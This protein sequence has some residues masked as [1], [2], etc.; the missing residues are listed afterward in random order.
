MQNLEL[1]HVQLRMADAV[2]RH[3]QEIFE[4][5]DAPTD[6]GGDE[7][8]LAAHLPEMGIP[9]EGH[10]DVT[11]DE[12]ADTDEDRVHGSLRDN[13]SRPAFRPIL[14]PLPA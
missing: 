8:G 3:L 1:A 11:E 2:G 7:P 4:E 13:G 14:A 12:E 6:E 5:G 10:E 9:G